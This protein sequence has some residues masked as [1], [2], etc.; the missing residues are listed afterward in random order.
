MGDHANTK[1]RVRAVVGCGGWAEF[2]PRYWK[3]SRSCAGKGIDA[4]GQA[5]RRPHPA[6]HSVLERSRRLLQI[7]ATGGCDGR[8]RRLQIQNNLRRWRTSSWAFGRRVSTASSPTTISSAC[9]RLS[10][11]LRGRNAPR[12][13]PGSGR[14]GDQ[15]RAMGSLSVTRRSVGSYANR[16]QLPMMDLWRVMR[17]G[18]ISLL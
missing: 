18:N 15:R 17:K 16:C 5:G 10:I 1:I 12:Q 7:C 13:Y 8:S 14:N 2:Q 3:S 11:G 4:D 9:Q 6:M